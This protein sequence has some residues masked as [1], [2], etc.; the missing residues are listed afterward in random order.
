M[1][2]DDV[3]AFTRRTRNDDRASVVALLGDEMFRAQLA[4]LAG[5]GELVG[6]LLWP[7]RWFRL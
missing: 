4:R 7:C 5:E 3:S 1:V 2:A 6:R